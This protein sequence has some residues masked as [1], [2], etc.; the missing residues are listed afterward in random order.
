ME[1]FS[2]RSARAGVRVRRLLRIRGA[3]RLPRPRNPFR[4]REAP[5]GAG[6]PPG[7]AGFPGML[8]PGGSDTAPFLPPSP[9]QEPGP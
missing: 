2:T 3:D 5:A 6:F 7:G 8:E 9:S 1:P 4:T